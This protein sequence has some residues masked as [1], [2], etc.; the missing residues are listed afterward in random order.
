[1][2]RI[3]LFCASPASTAICSAMDEKSTVRQSSR[4][5]DRQLSHLIDGQRRKP[6]NPSSGSPSIPKSNHQKGRKLSSSKQTDLSS[7]LGSSRYLLGDASFF[8]VS[9]D[10]DRLPALAPINL[11]AS[12][13]V[14]ESDIFRPSDDKVVELKVSLH[15]K[16]CEGKV[17]K[18]ISR[19]EG[20]TSFSVDFSAKK[21]TVIGDLT[22]LEVLASISKVKN[23]EFWPSSSS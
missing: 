4:A 21:V 9:L 22:P 3:D 18:H 11:T 23:A 7:P 2:K 14:S 16:G 5:I 19:M 8:G 1:M 6:H 10:Q 17:R 13:L 12:R 20:V 15:C